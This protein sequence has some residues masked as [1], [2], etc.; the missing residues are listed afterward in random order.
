[1]DLSQYIRLFVDEARIHFEQCTRSLLLLE[2]QPDNGEL[3]NEIFRMIHTLKGMAATLIEFPYFQDM[4]HLTHAMENLLDRLRTRDLQ[5]TTRVMDLLFACMDGLETL[6]NNVAEPEQ[7]QDAPLD[8]LLQGL[9]DV[10]SESPVVATAAIAPPKENVDWRERYAEGESL[11]IAQAGKSGKNCLEVHVTLEAQCEMK[12]ARALMVLRALEEQSELL[13]TFPPRD[14]LLQLEQTPDRFIASIITRLTDQQ[15]RNQA[16]DVSEVGDVRIFNLLGETMHAIHPEMVET[17]EDVEFHMPTLNEFEQRL[18]QEAQQQGLYTVVLG[19]RLFPNIL[20]KAARVAVIFRILEQLGEIIKTVPSVMDLEEERFG[21]F[22][23]VVLITT[24]APT[25][26][27]HRI[28]SV[29]EVRDTLDLV[30]MPMQ[31]SH[32]PAFPP[33][34][35]SLVIA[36]SG[37][38]VTQH[39]APPSASAQRTP[40][41]QPAVLRV[42]PA[43]FAQVMEQVRL[44]NQERT[45]L[46]LIAEELQKPSLL[47]ASRRIQLISHELQTLCAQLQRVA[48]EQVFNR[49]PRMVRDLARNLGKEIDLIISGED[50]EVDRTL[51]DDLSSALVHMLRNA[52]DHGIETPSERT[53]AGKSPRGEI[54]LSACYDEGDLLIEVRDD[55]RGINGERLKAKA[56]RHGLLS[57]EEALLLSPEGALQLIFTP[58]L[59][60]YE[61]VTDISGRG[62]GMDAVKN[63]IAQI[64]GTLHLTSAAGGGTR[65]HIRLPLHL[66]RVR[67]LLLAADNIYYALPLQSV[68][69]I[70]AIRPDELLPGSPVQALVSDRPLPVCALP[71]CAPERLQPLV[72]VQQRDGA[73][74]ILAEEVIGH[75]EVSVRPSNNGQSLPHIAGT[76]VLESG[77]TAWVLNADSSLM[78]L[79]PPVRLP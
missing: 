30:T 47:E 70:T 76:T 44:L 68:Q 77:Q 17:H 5:V 33:Q 67:A 66:A 53:E 8:F 51:I 79:L 60:T 26:I 69:A 71:G 48:M 29:A 15:V 24:E 61:N 74:A 58:G 38:E 52:A 59:S 14:V 64:G 4:T 13:K 32:R 40:R 63:Q 72:V 50:I 45:T 7:T 20:L 27:E 62:V 34:A 11:L 43:K 9:Q 22:F 41:T 56:L 35:A 6:I 36:S 25:T 65:M 16:Q 10:M 73:V 46:S 19:I 18:V 1:M 12:A 39:I 21:Q 55:G 37:G 23:E 3:L 31:E 54:H 75:M 2:H 49:F 57:A 28:L 78:K 42:D